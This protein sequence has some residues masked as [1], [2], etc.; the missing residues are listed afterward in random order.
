MPQ[1][2]GLAADVFR[3]SWGWVAT[4][5][6]KRGVQGVLLPVARKLDARRWIEKTAP[7]AVPADDPRTPPSVAKL[8][9][10]V[11]R[12]IEQYF[13]GRPVDFTT[14][15]LDLGDCPPFRRKALAALAK[16]GYGEKITYGVLAAAAGKPTA[17]RAAAGACA[18]NPLPLVIPC[19][20]VIASDGSPGGFS[21]AGGVA[22]KRRMLALEAGLA[23]VSLRGHA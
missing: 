9:A 17:A 8:L 20:R 15:P 13:A 12:L 1:N 3:V 18:R 10:T 7:D 19:H 4:V 21:A 2:S 23:R 6:S 22:L 14:L 16:V 11:R 5:A